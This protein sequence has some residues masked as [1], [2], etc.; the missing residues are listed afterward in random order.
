[1]SKYRLPSGRYLYGGFVF[2]RV[3]CQRNGC[4]LIFSKSVR[5][6]IDSVVV[7]KDGRYHIEYQ[8]DGKKHKATLVQD[9]DN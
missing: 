7:K 3:E 6:S 1:M 4:I 2:V 8:H 9:E 5:I